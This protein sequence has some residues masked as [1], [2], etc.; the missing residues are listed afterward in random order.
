[1]DYNILLDISAEIGYRLAMAGA[2]TYRVEESIS[3]TLAAYGIKGEVFVIPNCLHVSIMTDDG[4]S[5]TRMRRI[6]QHGNDLDTVEKYNSLSRRICAEKPEPSSI[7]AMLDETHS[8]CIRYKFPLYTLAHAMAAAGFTVFFGGSLLDCLWSAISGILIGLVNY[9][10][11]KQ[12][13]NSFFTTITAAFIMALTAYSAAGLG[14]AHNADTIIIGALMLLVPGLLFTNAMRD[15][16]F[17]DTN[18]G[19]NRIVQVLLIATAIGL[20]T[21]VA[22]SITHAIFG[23]L[24]APAV[25]DYPLVIDLLSLFIA[26][27][28][29]SMIFNI[30][31]KGIILCIVGSLICWI[32]YVLALRLGC[33]EIISYLIAGVICAVYSETLARIRKC[34]AIA[35]LVVAIFPIIPGAGI[36]YTTWHLLAKEMGLAL[37]RGLNTFAIAG[38]IAVGILIVSTVVRFW[39]QQNQLKKSKKIC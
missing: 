10:L 22:W 30:H 36:Y 26:V 38:V 15:F 35:Y 27:V 20:G 32:S 37:E 11:G 12:K 3:R 25:I 8:S 4:T 34:P 23:D 19:T 14:I 21:G 33:N 1:M 16:I 17:G 18:S 5:M 28:G 39:S 2:E 24:T 13:V 7:Q 9:F 29:F 31:G 6:G